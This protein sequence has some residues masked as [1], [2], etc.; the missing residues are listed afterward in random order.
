MKVF[1]CFVGAIQGQRLK[2]WVFQNMTKNIGGS[3]P[4]EPHQDRRLWFTQRYMRKI[5]ALTHNDGGPI[6]FNPNNQQ[7]SNTISVKFT[8]NKIET[9]DWR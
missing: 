5:H 1:G 7:H 3:G 8:Y 9:T 2:Y 6:L 4:P